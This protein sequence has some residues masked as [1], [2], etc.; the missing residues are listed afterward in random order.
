MN[1]LKMIGLVYLLKKQDKIYFDFPFFL[2]REMPK[3]AAV[4]A[5][6]DRKLC[7]TYFLISETNGRNASMNNSL[8]H[9]YKSGLFSFRNS[10]RSLHLVKFL[11]IN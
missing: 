8:I 10:K 5:P 9:V 3:L 1:N 11:N 6:P 7:N 4:V 2:F